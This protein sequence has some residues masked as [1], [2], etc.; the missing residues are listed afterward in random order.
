MKKGGDMNFLDQ[1]WTDE[2]IETLF[3]V[4]PPINELEKGFGYMGVILRNKEEDKL[5][6]HI[7]GKWYKSLSTHV[8]KAHGMNSREYKR[9][10]SL[11]LSFPL[12][13]RS[14]SRKHSER[15][16][17]KKNLKHLDKV[18]N[19]KKLQG[20]PSKRRSK[21]MK[22]STNCTGIRNKRGVC[23]A[24]IESRFLGIADMLGKS[25]S[26]RDLEKYDESLFAAIRRR[27]STLNNFR[28][29]MGYEVKEMPN[30]YSDAELLS[31]VRAFYKEKGRV[32]RANDF[33]KGSP[34]IITFRNHFGSWH[35]ALSCAGLGGSK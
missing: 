13:A 11:P 10:F 22:Y 35:R 31:Y 18:R 15:A 19:L 26:Q 5:Q 6:C 29:K 25:P 21:I 2:N 24:Q 9:Q 28:K 12:V 16:R 20:V 7:C 14:T 3:K 27:Y 34:N 23:E 8:N 30:K 17:D 32:P 4:E 1:A 33:R